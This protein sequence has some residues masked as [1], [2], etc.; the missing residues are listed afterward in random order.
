VQGFPFKI[1]VGQLLPL[2]KE[3]AGNRIPPLKIRGGQGELWDEGR[4]TPPACA[5]KRYRPPPP[6]LLRL[7]RLDAQARPP[8]K[9]RGGTHAVLPFLKIRG[10]Q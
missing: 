2:L 8:L 7:R 6:K 4:V 5:P 9:L 3:E 1:R 10:W